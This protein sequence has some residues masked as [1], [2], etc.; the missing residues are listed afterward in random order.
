MVY[1]GIV[2]IFKTADYFIFKVVYSKNALHVI[3]EESFHNR[4]C[5]VV[6]RDKHVSAHK[7]SSMNPIGETEVRQ[8]VYLFL[9]TPYLD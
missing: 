4:N 3:S 7:E 5:W 8:N 2:K 1:V 9:Q 6:N